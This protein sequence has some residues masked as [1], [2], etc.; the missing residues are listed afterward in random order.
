[1]LNRF[2]FAGRYNPKIKDYKFWKDGNE[3]KEIHSNSFLEQKLAYIHNNPVVA[4]IVGNPEK[5]IYSS[6]RNYCEENGLLD[7]VSIE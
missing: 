6:A 3:A 5:Y 2:E 7:I 4:E 1:M